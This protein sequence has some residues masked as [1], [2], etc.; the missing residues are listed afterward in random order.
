MLFLAAVSHPRSHLAYLFTPVLVI[1][2]FIFPGFC[3]HCS[4]SLY[5]CLT[6]STSLSSFVSHYHFSVFFCF[7]VRQKYIAV[8]RFRSFHFVAYFFCARLLLHSLLLPHTCCV[9]MRDDIE[10]VCAAVFISNDSHKYTHFIFSCRLLDW[11]ARFRCL[12]HCSGRAGCVSL[13][14]CLCADESC[15][16]R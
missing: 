4:P 3:W 5:S 7:R 1:F 8:S 15:A 12:I 6:Q 14:H 10:I 9:P 16:V 11:F 2:I 13:C